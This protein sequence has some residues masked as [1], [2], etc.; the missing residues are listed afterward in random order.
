MSPAFPGRRF[1]MA[2]AVGALALTAAAVVPQSAHAQPLGDIAGS[3]QAPA[4][5]PTYVT[6]VTG[7]RVQVFF[8][9]DGTTSALLESAGDH[10]TRR[11]GDDLYVIPVTAEKALAEGR[12]DPELFNVTGLVR[13]GYDDASRTDLPLLVTGSLPQ[14]RG[15]TGFSA[16]THLDSIGATAVTVAKDG[17][18]AAFGTLSG[19]N[20]RGLGT[21]KIW[22]DAK[23]EGTDLDPTTGVE[24]TGAPDVWDLGFNGE[25][26]KVAI[27]DT[28]YDAEHPD[29]AGQVLA[30]EDFTGDGSPLDRDGHGTHVASTIAGTGAADASKVGMAPGADLLIGRVLGSGG[31][32]T[33]WIVAGM[34]WAVAQGAD[35]VNMSLGST[36]PTDCT[37]PMAQAANELSAQSKTL[38]VVAAGNSGMRETVSSPGCATGVLTVGAVDGEG[39][40]ANFS[41]RGPVLGNHELKPD[42]T[43]PGVAI[44]GAA[45]GSPGEVPYTRMSGTS[46]ATPHVVG[47]VA[48]IR[49]AHPD[50][51]AQQVKAALVASVK[52]ETVDTVYDQGAGEM[53]VPGALDA[54][55]T[56]D[57]SVRL[58]DFAWPHGRDE[59]ATKNVTYTNDSA[60]PV[61]L[62]LKVDDITGAD[63][64]RV[65]SKAITLG[66]TKITIPA[67]GTATVPVTANGYLHGLDA[68]SYGEIG[69]RIIATGRNGVRVTTAV[70]FWLE[71]E[72]VDVTVKAI[73]R[74]GAP[75]TGGYLDL[76]DAHQ[77][78]RSLIYFQGE[79]IPLRLRADS[80]VVSGF[81]R[82]TNTDGTY[83]YTYVGDPEAR[84]TEDT[85]ITLDARKAKA[86]TV[87]GDRPLQIRSGSLHV[88]RSFDRWLVDNSVFAARNPSFY[89][90]PTDR[91]RDGEFDFGVYL[92]ATDPAV[93][94]EN[95]SYVYNLSFTGDRVSRDQSHRVRDRDLATVTENFH[96][97]RT[98]G[99]AYEWTRVLQDNGGDPIYAGSGNPVKVP[100]TRTAY[101][102]PGPRWQQIATTLRI[103]GETWFGEAQTYDRRQKSA[104][105]W[106]RMPAHNSLGRYDDGTPGRVAER[107]GT[108]VGFSFAPLKDADGH[109][110]AGGF[111]DI[112]NLALWKNG[113]LIG[114]NAWPSGQ[115]QIGSDD[116][117]LRVEVNQMRFNKAGWELAKGTVTSFEFASTRPD[118]DTVEALPIAVPSYDAPVDN[119]NLAPNTATAF[120]V[121]VGLEGQ[122]GYDPGAITSFTA[123]VS[124]DAI[125]FMGGKPVKDYTWTDVPVV[126]RDGKWFALVDNTANAGGIAS[127]W[128]NTVDSHGTKTEQIT[129]N[130]YGVA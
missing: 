63:G 98:P 38:F 7:D 92:R 73:D 24:Q 2:F 16:G 75:A 77:P 62:S 49:Q 118:G 113:E 53:W 116:C 12:L 25:G 91:V 121:E 93:A 129:V 45:L 82:T 19:D 117:V 56:S 76:T 21:G 81:I 102:T 4:G 54:V 18:A 1:G 107:Q 47:A 50:W 103:R 34:E 85:V 26:T 58:A 57:T 28:G 42:L 108:L 14:T 15:L 72:S 100:S 109:W 126:N 122:D 43:A 17:L 71:P 86:V 60:T 23:V 127:L 44:T 67:H 9:A 84:L 66:K 32:Q 55:V 96:A 90:A 35:V 13:Q 99:L 40:T 78:A 65:S 69:G 79:D 30:A 37:D 112:G 115:A 111:G 95:S 29:L 74:N 80:H 123:K 3:S 97:Q 52:K 59:R 11:V 8:A 10:Y 89:A 6:L 106:F 104:V 114:T 88:G 130:L 20:A 46:M 31:G 22:L 87:T 124:F 105:D 128:I 5:Q 120:P 64:E 61:T 39:A 48:L 33:S 110:A 119:L 70:G 36:L 125:D 41:S 101:Y 94:E 83:S 51:T 68:S 27:L